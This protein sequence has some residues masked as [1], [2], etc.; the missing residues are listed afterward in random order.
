MSFKQWSF[1]NEKKHKEEEEN[2]ISEISLIDEAG[3]FMG[4]SPSEY[5]KRCSLKKDLLN[6]CIKDEKNLIQKSKIQWLKE[7][8]EYSNFFHRY[9]I[10]RKRKSEY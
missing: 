10:P 4:I 9:L 6:L 5:A 7:G 3:K 8:D 1:Q 2:I